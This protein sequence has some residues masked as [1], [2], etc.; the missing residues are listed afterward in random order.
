[1]TVTLK[2]AVLLIYAILVAA[3]VVYIQ[4][5]EKP[6]HGSQQPTSCIS[7]APTKLAAIKKAEGKEFMGSRSAGELFPTPTVDTNC[8]PTADGF[9]YAS[10][11]SS[12]HPLDQVRKP[13]WRLPTWLL[14]LRTPAWA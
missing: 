1:M 8:R 13:G 5:S 7:P 10:R 9:Y 12:I 11:C 6:I 3:A 14:R 4:N 2:L